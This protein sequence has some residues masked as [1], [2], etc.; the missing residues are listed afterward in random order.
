MSRT[1]T[2]MFD[3][4]DD[5]QTAREALES[6]GLPARDIAIH[7]EAGQARA[8]GH[9]LW[10]ELLDMFVP[11]EDRHAFH[12]G[13]RRG[14]TLVTARVEDDRVDTATGVLEGAGPVDLEER[15]AQWRREGWG[16]APRSVTSQTTATLGAATTPAG[17]WG[18][19]ARPRPRVG[20]YP[21]R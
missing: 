19:G 21:T 7:R 5:A 11:E 17:G 16:T 12:E 10:A 8:E 20:A 15:A 2:A 1:L 14:G 6:A 3:S 18:D 4:H 13:V 9:G